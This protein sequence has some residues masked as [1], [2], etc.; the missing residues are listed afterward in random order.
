LVG[1][2]QPDVIE[3]RQN[4]FFLTMEKYRERLVELT[5][6]K[7][8]AELIKDHAERRLVLQ[9]VAHDEM[10]VNLND[11]HSMGIRPEVT[12]PYNLFVKAQT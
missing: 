3:Y 7:V 5:V 1:H 9:V 8:E 11:G 4:V 6:G 12:C 10:A 2:E